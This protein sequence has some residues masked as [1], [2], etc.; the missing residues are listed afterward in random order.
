MATAGGSSLEH[1][2][3]VVE[4]ERWRAPAASPPS[5]A[6]GLVEERRQ[7]GAERE[8]L[9]VVG[10]Q[11]ELALVALGA[12]GRQLGQRGAGGLEHLRR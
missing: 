4:E 5:A 1:L 12:R 6:R 9:R 11:A 7:L 3:G 8:Q 2:S 10:A